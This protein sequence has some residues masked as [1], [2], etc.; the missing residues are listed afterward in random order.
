[1]KFSLFSFESKARVAA[2]LATGAA[3]RPP[4][5]PATPEQVTQLRQLLE[6]NEKMVRSYDAARTTAY[7]QDFTSTFG[8]ANAE[9]L[10]SLYLSRGRARTLVKDFSQGKA[11]QRTFQN[12]TV[13]HEPFKLKMRV[14]KYTSG[15]DGTEKF[16]PETETNRRIMEEWEVAGRPENFS[17]RKNMSRMEG[18]R[19]LEAS[20]IRDGSVLL[21]HHRGF[22]HNPYGYA[23]DLLEAD[24]LDTSYMGRSPDG[25][26]I[27]FSVEYDLW[28]TPV[29]Y[30]VLTRHPGDP[31]GNRTDGSYGS[32]GMAK[33]ADRFREQ[34]PAADIIHFN[35]LRDRAEQD[36]G[37]TELD[38]IMQDLHRSRQYSIA[39]AYAAIASCCKPFWVKKEYP[40]GLQFTAENMQALLNPVTTGTE[41]GDGSEGDGAKSQ[42]TIG[43]RANVMSPA[44]TEVMNF[45]ESLQ[46]L[47]PKFPIEAA[48]EYQKDG[49]RSAA[50]GAGIAYQSI[51]GDFQ[52]L[53]FSASRQSELPQRDYAKVRQRH[54]ID[55]VVRQHFREWLKYA[56]L[57]GVLELPISRLEEFVNAAH[58]QGRRWA[59]VNPLQDSQCDVM[60]EQAGFRSPQQIQDEREDGKDIDELYAEI[61]E[62]RAKQEAYGLEFGE[63]AQTADHS[64]SPKSD[65]D[66]APEVQPKPKKGG[67]QT[68]RQR[69][70]NG[71]GHLTTK[72]LLLMQGDGR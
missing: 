49:M 1:M 10:T 45:G 65:D 52:N 22:P 19:I 68:I 15:P 24:R 35:N 36:V 6:L 31:F 3:L 64:G 32:Y 20:A 66:D 43:A 69:N 58:F 4:M 39:L 13:G 46:Q 17:V 60:D 26:V 33:G 62:A 55:V 71:N 59:Y 61:A 23:V 40:T 48:S 9:I 38:C 27:R 50:V 41:P 54:M 70:G 8:S 28:N 67:R 57:S 63:A 34:V 12:N 47:D 16:E 25:N 14:G 42:Q 7:N 51:T 37:M 53:G 56:I 21:R 18:Y 5:P 44:N 2:P 30:W 11:I 29:A 72:D